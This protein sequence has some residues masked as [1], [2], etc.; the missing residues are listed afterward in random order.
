MLGYLNN[1]TAT[2]AAFAP[3]GWVRSGD[4]GKRGSNGL[5]YI[6]DRKKDLIKV[7]GWQVSPAEIEEVILMNSNVLDAAVVG[8]K[9]P[10]PSRD[11]CAHAYIVL[12]NDVTLTTHQVKDWVERHLAAYKIPKEVFFME[13]LPRNPTGKLIRRSIQTEYV[14]FTRRKSERDLAG[15]LVRERPP[16][17]RRLT[18]SAAMQPPSVSAYRTR[19]RAETDGIG[20]MESQLLRQS[21]EDRP[22]QPLRG[23]IGRAH[24]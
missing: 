23:Q 1:E 13:S 10:E 6:T 3:I 2:Q 15:R 8:C 20:E 24:V 16:P 9:L 19:N 18:T 21:L 4:V 17:S 12:K 5:Y 22:L 7:R 11:E 14:E